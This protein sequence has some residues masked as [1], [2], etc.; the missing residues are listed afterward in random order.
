MS[1]FGRKNKKP[2]VNYD[3]DAQQPAVRRSICTG[4]M[5]AG[6]IDNKTGKFQDVM[7]VDGQAGLESFCQSIGA[8]VDAVKT[9]Y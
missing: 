6:F 4:E 9:I 5:T 8:D 1:L 2:V 7:L 3:P